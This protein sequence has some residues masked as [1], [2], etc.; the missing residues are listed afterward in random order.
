MNKTKKI[1]G[2]LTAAT[3]AALLTLIPAATF[4]ATVDGADGSNVPLAPGEVQARTCYL[5][6]KQL[7]NSTMASAPRNHGKLDASYR[8]FADCAKLAVS[9]GKVIHNG[10]RVPW[11]PEYFADTVGATYAQLQLASITDNPEHCS[12]LALARDLADQAQQT[13]GETPSPG[14]AEFEN[15]W[16]I[17]QANVKT[18]AL[19]CGKTASR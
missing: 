11:M 17:L 16:A 3:F 1:P 9:T 18:Q 6:A 19:A 7:W 2:S 10:E 15:M 5:H 14:N 4:A 13:E 12:H 8:T